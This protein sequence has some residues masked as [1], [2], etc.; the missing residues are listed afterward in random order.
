MKKPKGKENLKIA[1]IGAGAI[2]SLLGAYLTEAGEDVV[3]IGHRDQV[4]VIKEKGLVIDGIRGKKKIDLKIEESLNE[5]PDLVF[6]TVKTQ[7]VA[8]TARECVPFIA[9]VP[10]VA[11]QNGIR[12]ERLLHQAIEKADIITSIVLF[13]A[14]YLFPGEV[15]HNFE[16][17]IIIGRVSGEKDSRLI[18]IREVLNR[19]FPTVIAENIKGIEWLKLVLNLNNALPGI[20]GEDIQ[21]TFLSAPICRIGI[22]L[23][24]EAVEVMA[25]AKIRLIDLP[26]FPLSRLEGLLALPP[27]EAARIYS[28]I[29]TGLSSSSLPGSILQ[30]IKRGRPTEIDYLNG[31]IVALGRETNVSTP[32]NAKIVDLV[33]RVEEDKRFYSPEELI[34]EVKL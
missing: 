11:M 12:S 18:L 15:F 14:T 17:K 4:S 30:S 3:L 33:H 5:K 31:E 27:E 10:I 34:E 29:M 22:G 28:R 2:G 1:I 6:L 20:I 25:K 21:K 32:L 9:R 24:T 23:M 16:G 19:A 7:D 26:D 8:A 13:G